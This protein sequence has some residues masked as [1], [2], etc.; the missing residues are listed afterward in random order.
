M[1]QT[2][3]NTVFILIMLGSCMITDIKSR[4]IP[5]KGLLFFGGGGILILL[6][7][8]V[9]TGF[10]PP[11]GVVVGIFLLLI[12][13]ITKGAVGEGDA[14]LLMITGMLLCF[15]EN[16]ILL[17]AASVLAAV[18]GIILMVVHKAD[19][20]EELPF[21]PFLFISYLGMVLL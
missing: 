20:R 15:E 9:M 3:V 18:W 10:V 13:R 7:K 8:T 2:M 11:F 16:L 19:R 21:V 5:V 1:N 12:S 14:I 6:T 17:L 4:E